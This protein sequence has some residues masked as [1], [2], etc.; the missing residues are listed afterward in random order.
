ML[1]MLYKWRWWIWGI[2]L[3]AWSVALL[4]PVPQHPWIV[5]EFHVD[6]KVL[7]AKAVHLSAYTVLAIL[8]GW[9]RAPVR[10]RFLLMFL[11]MVHGTVTEVLQYTLEFIGRHG[12]LLDVALDNAG[13]AVGTLIAWRW[14]TAPPAGTP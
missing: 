3:T 14:W 1:K 9:L 12:E 5:G 6:R 8:T 2:Y 10:L 13:I 7:F 11:L 4:V